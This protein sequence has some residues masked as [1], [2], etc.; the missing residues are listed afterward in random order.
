MH[1]LENNH[2]HL[3]IHAEGYSNIDTGYKIIKS[4]TTTTKQ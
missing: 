4:A 1:N 2:L 3:S